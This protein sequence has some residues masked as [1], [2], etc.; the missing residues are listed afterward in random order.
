MDEP[1]QLSLLVDGVA[2][3]A[4]RVGQR[5][6]TAAE[7]ANL[8]DLKSIKNLTLNSRSILAA[9]DFELLT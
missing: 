3:G 4:D 8:A 7:H 1:R 5:S 9:F 2:R 6:G